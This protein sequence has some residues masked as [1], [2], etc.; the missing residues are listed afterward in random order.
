[1]IAVTVPW[2]RPVGIALILTAHAHRKK[3]A[4]GAITRM[5]TSR[6]MRSISSSSLLGA[7][8]QND[9]QVLQHACRCTP[10]I[11]LAIGH[12]VEA[13]LAAFGDL[14]AV[15]AVVLFI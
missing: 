1:M 6:T 8:R 3:A 10:N 12:G 15:D 5:I 9:L 11:T 2:L 14:A 7:R 4:V 13:P